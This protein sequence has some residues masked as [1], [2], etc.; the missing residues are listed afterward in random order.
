MYIKILFSFQPLSAS[1]KTTT[2]GSPSN[3]EILIVSEFDIFSHP[4]QKLVTTY[5]LASSND[6]QTQGSYLTIQSQGLGVDIQVKEK[7]SIDRNTYSGEYVLQLKY[8]VGNSNYDNEFSVKAGKTQLNLLLRLLN[9]DLIRASNRLNFN[10]EEQIID[11]ELSSYDNNP[12]V[13]HLEIKNF[14]TFKYIVG[15]KSK[16]KKEGSQKEYL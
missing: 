16:I 7:G 12:L 4:A 2:N 15:F 8:H 14:N 5:K 3:G 10:K 6:A 13:A 9:V 1:V 11:S